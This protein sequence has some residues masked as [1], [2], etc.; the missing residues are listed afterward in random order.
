MVV[1]SAAMMKT[2]VG[3]ACRRLLNFQA[4]N[5]N[6]VARLYLAS[7][8]SGWKQSYDKAVTGRTF[9]NGE[10]RDLKRRVLRHV[11]LLPFIAQY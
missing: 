5:R 3:C 1:S 9:V 4:T 6:D 10:S 11:Y 8:V 7:V 2:G